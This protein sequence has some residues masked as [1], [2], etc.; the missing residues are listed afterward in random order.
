VCGLT[1][2]TVC[3]VGLE[4][5][6]VV[7][8]VT[9]VVFFV[10]SA[11][12]VSLDI[13]IYG[14]RNQAD[15][16]NAILA[17]RERGVKVRVIVDKDADTKNYYSSTPKL[18]TDFGDA[19]RDDFAADMRTKAKSKPYDPDTARCAAPAGFKGPPQCLGYDLGDRCLV[20]VHATEEDLAFQGDIMHNKFVIADGRKVWTGST[21]ISDS[22]SGGYNANVVA[23][24]D[25]P[26]VAGWYTEEFDQMWVHGRFHNEKIAL[27]KR[28][29]VEFHPDLAVEVF[30]SPQDEPMSRAVRPLVQ[31]AKERIDIPVFYLTEKG[32][33]GDLIAAHLRGVKIRVLLDATSATNG[34]SKH[35]VLRAAGIPVKI[36]NW[37]GKM[38]MKSMVVDGRITVVGSMNFTSAGTRSNDEN[39]VVIYSRAIAEQFERDFEMLWK[40][41]PDKWLI[42]RPGAESLDSP[43]A[44]ADGFDNDYNKLADDKDPRCRPN[45]PPLPP[46]P[47]HR[48]VPKKEGYDLIKG[49]ILEG[50]RRVFYTPQSRLYPEIRVDE[51][52]GGLWFCSEGQAWDA[53]FRRSRE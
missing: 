2:F 50:G 30:F 37:G 47:D 19:V 9:S 20:G 43:V 11:S 22:C 1:V 51:N 3:F 26:E 4:A 6:I 45:G 53:G 31:A 10:A 16:Y 41:V 18:E 46:L 14:I 17:A 36:E 33:T 34:Y 48:I 5:G 42:G 28:R 24:I 25:H 7:A 21:N 44:C 52:A 32:L 15:L 8:I 12:R 49:V 40:S 35:E 39:T 38:H 13:A 27:G 23:V 29:R